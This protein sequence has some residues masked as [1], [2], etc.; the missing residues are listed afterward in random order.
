MRPDKTYLNVIAVVLLGLYAFI[1]MPVQVWHKHAAK[2][3]YYSQLTVKAVN[4]DADN[5]VGSF[6]RVDLKTASTQSE[7]GIMKEV[8][9]AAANADNCKICTHHYSSYLESTGCI[10]L[11][12]VPFS[13]NLYSSFQSSFPREEV[14][15]FSNKGPPIKI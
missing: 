8:S 5:S 1:A 2:Q 9:S 12:K 7:I 10:L 6:G 13:K 3:S 11:S 15:S 4:A 14:L